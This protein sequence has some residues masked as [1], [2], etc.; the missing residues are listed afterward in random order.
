ME[1][2]VSLSLLNC[3]NGT[4]PDLTTNWETNSTLPKRDPEIEDIDLTSII[5]KN[6]EV[7]IKCIVETT[8][9]YIGTSGWYNWRS[10]NQKGIPASKQFDHYAEIFNAIELDNT[11]YTNPR[12][13]TFEKWKLNYPKMNFIVKA[14]KYITHIKMMENPE[15]WWPKTWEL[16]K[17][18]KPR[19]GPILFQMKKEY[20]FNK[21]N[22][23]K[24]IKFANIIE[25]DVPIAIEF[26]SK[27]WDPKNEYIQDL[28]HTSN[29][30]W[31]VTHIEKEEDLDDGWCMDLET[32]LEINQSF[33]YIRLHGTKEYHEEMDY[34]S[35]MMTE[36]HNQGLPAY[37]FFNNTEGGAS[38]DAQ[39]L[40]NMLYLTDTDTDKCD[41]CG[42]EGPL[43]F[44]KDMNICEEC[45]NYDFELGN[46]STIGEYDHEN[47]FND[48]WDIL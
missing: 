12:P 4:F 11:F 10:Q 32:A 15:I 42:N 40:Q 44:W 26:R 16:Y 37:A 25:E 6:K 39:L 13:S 5:A 29:W 17:I 28:F 23:I 47:L 3:I 9:Y 46:D 34:I 8:E 27:T 18:L 14:N 33:L 21:E 38:Y 36:A 1:K 45:E 30:G 19:L 24:L 2:Y 48:P 41:I 43:K 20:I 7:F 31:V 35:D 22:L